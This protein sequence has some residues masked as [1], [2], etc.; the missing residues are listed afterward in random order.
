MPTHLRNL[1]LAGG[2]ATLTAACA[3][4][5]D[6]ATAEQYREYQV[7]EAEAE[8][9]VCSYEQVMGSLRRERICIDEAEVERQR[10]EAR[11]NV[12]RYQRSAPG[13]PQPGLPPG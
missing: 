9:M 7:A 10:R 2:L 13:P 8:G 12:E 1:A 5:T 11:E 6:S 4:P 3:T